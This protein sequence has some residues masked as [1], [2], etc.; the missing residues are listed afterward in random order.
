MDSGEADESGP[1]IG[2]AVRS[3]FAHQI[4]RPENAIR[5]GRRSGCFLGELIVRIAVRFC[6]DAEAIAEPAQRQS[7]RLRYAHDVPSA[8]DS[9]AEGVNPPF[10]IEGRT[11]G[12]A[13]D[14]ARCADG[15]AHGAGTNDSR[16]DGSSGLVACPDHDGRP[17]AQSGRLGSAGR[18]STADIRRFQQPREQ[19]QVDSCGP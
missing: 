4:G 15:R 19:L 13:E 1:R 17:G 10:G 7:G 11:I 5:S 9:V 2:I 14:Y 3:T 8:G 16:A 12:G 18:Y 6:E